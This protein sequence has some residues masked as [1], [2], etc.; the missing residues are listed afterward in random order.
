MTRTISET[1]SCDDIIF[2]RVLGIPL[3][4]HVVSEHKQYKA[5]CAL[6]DSVDIVIG[7]LNEQ[8]MMAT[9]D[10]NSYCNNYPELAQYN[11]QINFLHREIYCCEWVLHLLDTNSNDTPADIRQEVKLLNQERIVM[12]IEDLKSRNLYKKSHVHE[13]DSLVNTLTQLTY[14][15]LYYRK[16]YTRAYDENFISLLK[17]CEKA[18]I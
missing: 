15:F 14:K 11:N 12:M 18:K 10:F 16:Q 13:F 17:M 6:I 1:A 7:L 5:N 4:S 8:R 2:A 9:E 3:D